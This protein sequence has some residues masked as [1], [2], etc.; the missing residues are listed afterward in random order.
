MLL[1]NIVLKKLPLVKSTWLIKVDHVLSVVK[2]E[3]LQNA[4]QPLNVE[5]FT[6]HFWA[7]LAQVTN[8]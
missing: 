6:F 2:S 1:N 4:H 7:L 5:A 8:M 3:A